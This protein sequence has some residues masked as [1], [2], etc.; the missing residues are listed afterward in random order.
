[1]RIRRV[2]H[3]SF[4]SKYNKQVC[5]SCNHVTRLQW[6]LVAEA[7]GC[8]LCPLT[9]SGD[10]GKSRPCCRVQGVIVAFADTVHRYKQTVNERAF[11]SQTEMQTAVLQ[12]P[13]WF[14][15][16]DVVGRRITVCNGLTSQPCSLF[17]ARLHTAESCCPS[18]RWNYRQVCW[19]LFS[20]QYWSERSWTRVSKD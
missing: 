2:R 5:V 19:L 10:R 8:D 9:I 13:S 6:E 3:G 14:T 12:T 7:R 15:I 17:T 11:V 18:R 4:S 1:M 20:S 16:S